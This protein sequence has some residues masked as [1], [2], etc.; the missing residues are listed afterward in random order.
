M[1]RV[2]GRRQVRG[3]EGRACAFC[4]AAEVYVLDGGGGGGGVDRGG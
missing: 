4:T 2:A 3:L 1:A